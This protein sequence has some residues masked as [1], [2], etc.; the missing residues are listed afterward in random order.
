[1]LEVLRALLADGHS[2]AVLELVEKLVARNNELERLLSQIRSPLK[3]NEGVSS[4]QLLLLLDGLGA[5]AVQGLNA[6][7]EKLR[8]VSAIDDKRKE[9]EKTP[10]PRRQPPLRRPLPENLRR[11]ANPIPVPDAERPCPKCGGTR[12][13][14]GHDVCRWRS[15]S[16]PLHASN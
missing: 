3:K 8:A 7:D 14:I 10:S 11:V 2:E 6:A 12:D 4:Q 13:C 9:E 16:S 15:E 1:V 5:E